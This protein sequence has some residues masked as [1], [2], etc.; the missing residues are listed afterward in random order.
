[1]DSQ[2]AKSLVSLAVS[3]VLVAALLFIPAGTLDWANWP[4]YIDPRRK[5]TS[6]QSI[7]TDTYGIEV[8]YTD[9]VND[10]TPEILRNLDFLGVDALIPIGG[11]DTLSYGHRLHAEGV[12]IIASPKTMDNDVYGTDYCIGFSTAVTRSVQLIHQLRTSTGK[13]SSRSK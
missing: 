12:R 3:L 7:F 10:I 9:D 2:V 13:P 4:A 6:T 8:D 5:K 1:M 11:D